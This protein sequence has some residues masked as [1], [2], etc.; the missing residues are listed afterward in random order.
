MRRDW[1]LHSFLNGGHTA[2][3]AHTHRIEREAR[4]ILLHL[5]ALKQ[6]FI[7]NNTYV[8]RCQCLAEKLIIF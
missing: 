3:K 4:R 5:K 8:P 7:Y 1:S 2:Q 6:N